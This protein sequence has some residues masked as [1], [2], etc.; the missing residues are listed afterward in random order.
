[1]GSR[2]D[3]GWKI[4]FEKRAD[5]EFLFHVKGIRKIIS[6]LILTVF[7]I[8]YLIDRN[9]HFHIVNIFICLYFVFKGGV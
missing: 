8:I 1:M 2:N 5:D 6:I 3:K 4:H 9:S 7:T